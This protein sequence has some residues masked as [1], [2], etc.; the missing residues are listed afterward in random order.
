MI[1]AQQQMQVY[2]IKGAAPD[3]TWEVDVQGLA[4][5]VENLFRR[6]L[7]RDNPDAYVTVE[8]HRSLRLAITGD[9]IGNPDL[10]S[11]HDLEQYER[12]AIVMFLL[13]MEEGIINEV[14]EEYYARVEALLRAK[15]Q[16][17]AQV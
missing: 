5:R 13:E 11:F 10:E 2:L 8:E 9:L 15:E 12:R 1:R 16:M 7:R 3:R 4:M 17:N 14:K 6:P